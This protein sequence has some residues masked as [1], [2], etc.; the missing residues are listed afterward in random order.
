MRSEECKGLYETL[1]FV[2]SHNSECNGVNFFSFWPQTVMTEPSKKYQ[3]RT[4]SLSYI[5]G[6]LLTSSF[7]PERQDETQLSVWP[8]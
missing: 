3:G 5:L 2:V 8:L 1:H 6:L 4:L 7:T